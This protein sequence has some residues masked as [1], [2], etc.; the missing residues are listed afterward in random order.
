MYLEMRSLEISLMNGINVIIKRTSESSLTVFP[1]YEH[2]GE[3]KSLQ[4]ERG[5]HQNLSILVPLSQTSSFQNCGNKLLLFV[6]YPVGG[7][8]L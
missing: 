4:K 2:T 5:P 8:L 1:P 6:S 3:I 7:V